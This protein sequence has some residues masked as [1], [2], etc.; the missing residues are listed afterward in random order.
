MT[1]VTKISKIMPVRAQIGIMNLIPKIKVSDLS[2]LS[3]QS[4]PRIHQ[5][6]IRR[7]TTREGTSEGNHRKREKNIP[8]SRRT[9]R[10]NILKITW[11]SRSS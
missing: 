10:L 1:H 6:A 7:T 3:L 11:I 5:R 2:Y 9:Y 8:L 4:K